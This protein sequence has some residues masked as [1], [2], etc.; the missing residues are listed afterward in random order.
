M[1]STLPGEIHI[2]NWLGGLGG[3][4]NHAVLLVLTGF[5]APWRIDLNFL[6]PVVYVP[7]GCISWLFAASAA[8][9]AYV[10]GEGPRRLLEDPRPLRPANKLV[11]TLTSVALSGF[12][13]GIAIQA[14]ALLTINAFHRE[15][16]LL[17]PSPTILVASLMLMLAG[18]YAIAAT[19]ASWISRGH[20]PREVRAWFRGV[21][22]ALAAALLYLR[23]ILPDVVNEWCARQL[24]DSGI[25]TLAYATAAA[26]SAVAYWQWR[27]VRKA[28]A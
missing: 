9:G 17:A 28:S 20:T 5:V 21:A 24:T 8:G 25:A 7:Y 3:V 4:V 1:K 15:G 11:R 19:G 27:A 2:Q 12:V 10:S 22:V 26:L 18:C 13:F 6:D 23:D 16:T 14:G